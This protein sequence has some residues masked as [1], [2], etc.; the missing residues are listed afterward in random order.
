MKTHLIAYGLIAALAGCT[1]QPFTID[2]PLRVVS[3]EPSANAVDVGREGLVIRV[4]FSEAL[5]E[6]S[7]TASG[8]FVLEAIGGEVGTLEAPIVAPATVVYQ[9]GESNIVTI[10]PDSTLPFSTDYR[11]T[12]GTSLLRQRDNGPLPIKVT[13]LFSTEDPPP[14]VVIGT[15]PSPG[16]EAVGIDE[17][18]TVVFS[19]NVNCA[20]V[21][22]STFTVVE[23]PIDPPSE[24]ITHACVLSCADNIVTCDPVVSFGK[25]SH[26]TVTL[27]ASVESARATRRGGQLGTDFSFTFSTENPPPLLVV[28]TLPGNGQ[29]N[30]R[31]EGLFTVIFSEA[32]RCTTIDASSFKVERRD[33]QPLTAPYSTV[34]GTYTCDGATV[35]FDADPDVG[36]DDHVRISLASSIESAQATSLGGQLAQSVQ[37]EFDIV[38]VPP[39]QIVSTVPMDE[40]VN[41]GTDTTI[42]VVFNQSVLESRLCPTVSGIGTGACTTEPN[43]WLW[44]EGT[45]DIANRIPLELLSYNDTTYTAVFKP[46]DGSGDIDLA[47]GLRYEVVIRGGSTGVANMA[48]AELLA[49]YYFQFR[50]GIN[51][52]IQSVTPGDLSDD[53]SVATP[54]CVQFFKDVDADTVTSSTFTVTFTDRFGRALTVSADT[55]IYPPDG[56]SFP[57][58][59]EA[60][61]EV[62]LATWDGYE[63]PRTLLYDTT[64][65]VALAS[66]ITFNGGTDTDFA[67]YSWTF[68]T[69][70]APVPVGSYARNHLVAVDPLQ[71]ATE[72]PV[73]SEI[74]IE[75]PELVD[76]AS[77]DPADF[78]LKQGSTQEAVA[79]ALESDG[80]TVKVTPTALLSFGTLYTLTIQSGPTG[81]LTLQGEWLDVSS[82]VSFTTSP[83]TLVSFSPP[84]GTDMA[85]ATA[86]VAVVF[87]RPMYLPSVTTSSFY[88]YDVTVGAD[89]AATVSLNDA[90]LDSALLMPFPTWTSGN[91]VTVSLNT[92]AE[93]YLGN[94]MPKLYTVEY[95]A[96][97]GAPAENART[98]E[99]IALAKVS[100][101]TGSVA[102][103]QEFTI[104]FEVSTANKQL[105]RM[106]PATFND[107]T[108]LIK[109]VDGC[110][111]AAGSFIPQTNT[112]TV[113]AI[114]GQDVVRFKPTKSFLHGCSYQITLKAAQFANIHTVGADGAP[115]VV[116]TVVGES[117]SPTVQSLVPANGGIKADTTFL[118]DFSEEIDPASVNG[119][120]ITLTTTGGTAV[121]AQLTV[122][123]D[124]VTLIPDVALQPGDSPYALEV[125]VGVT[126]LAGNALGASASSSY[127]VVAPT[128]VSITPPATS[129]GQV[130]FVF[131]A[132]LDPATVTFDTLDASG[133]ISVA[134]ADNSDKVFGIVTLSSDGKTVT[135]SPII[136]GLTSG[137]DYEA[138]ASTDIHD[139]GGTALAAEGTQT[140]TAP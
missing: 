102:S 104:T 22:D 96:V 92:D 52:F 65:T 72:V 117:I 40:D 90:D 82:V 78:V 31:P 134:R 61:F 70:S 85:V 49:D 16:G 59:R 115:D 14:L 99:A 51:P 23:T 15:S 114:G 128:L 2:V 64:Y 132:A 109:D 130:V 21:T 30:V 53:V 43:V 56:I 126:D 95:A 112:F 34:P 69:G 5:V 93:D 73:N 103:Q 3:V 86:A 35:S 66:G 124:Q 84:G 10:T 118:I 111:G 88:G 129:N 135:F 8:S 67:G 122:R 136:D 13:S 100:P 123:G 106:V 101:N 25:T 121:P 20:S 68:T 45:T 127:T 44:P 138:K 62:A 50:V 83:G 116:F 139:V 71:N 105:N 54:I 89:L 19:E 18:I 38:P 46:R 108:I 6:S 1:D 119:T 24:P 81:P 58:S 55:G 137:V 98:P 133:S 63:N 97:N 79:V 42:T 11:L 4:G 48:G 9:G 131:D 87:S 33:A 110:N 91:R 75:W 29:D 39:I 7:A 94:P 107:Q 125:T 140:F 77:L 76:A 60:C 27:A 28:S 120:T 113:G 36:W 26:V 37:Y 17:N 74:F 57:N 41:V 80:F 32:V 47:A 12:I